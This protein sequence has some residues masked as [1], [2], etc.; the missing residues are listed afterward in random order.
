MAVKSRSP[1][2]LLFIVVS[3]L[4]LIIWTCCVYLG[5]YFASS[6]STGLSI[7]LSL[8][9]GAL[10]SV[11][12]F[13]MRRYTVFANERFRVRDSKRL[14]WIFFGLYMLVS[15]GSAWYVL[16]SVAVTSTI[17]E[18]KKT[19]ALDELGAI[20][21]VIDSQKP[22][23]SYSEYVDAEVAR[24]RHA[25]SETSVQTLD[26]QAGELRDLLTRQSGFTGLQEEVK[27]LW[28]TADWTVREWDL[29]Y[30][31]SAA[32]LIHD[33][34][35]VWADSLAHCSDAANIGDYKAMHTPYK[36]P[37]NVHNNADLYG[38]FTSI[39]A[40]D[41]SGWAIP[42]MLVSQLLILSSWLGLVGSGRSKPEGITGSGANFDG[43][44]TWRDD[45]S[46]GSGL[47]AHKWE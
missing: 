41:F 45:K 18:Q 11:F 1:L 17:K 21:H 12:F 25:N 43:G 15:V 37:T 42:L 27:S 3:I 30:L 2:S 26:A 40:A 38:S 31:P 5:M 6:G 47:N 46:E 4:G 20:Y 14:Q 28:Q 29:Q 16:H 44:R 32:R 8:C 7:P 9:I 39:T 10:M 35:N 13:L 22:A 19:L 36:I 24:F 33:K 23:G 34:Y